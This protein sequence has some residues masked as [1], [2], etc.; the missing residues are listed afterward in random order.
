MNQ[1]PFITQEYKQIIDEESVLSQIAEDQ[2]EQQAVLKNGEAVSV[3][4][5][6]GLNIKYEQRISL[7]IDGVGLYRTEIPF[8]LQSGFPSEDEQKNRYRENTLFLPR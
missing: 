7:G 1:S 8:M 4:L 5:N 6:A 3:Q 2:L